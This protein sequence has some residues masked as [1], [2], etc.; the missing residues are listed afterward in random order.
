MTGLNL[1][2]GR[3]RE[4]LPLSTSGLPD[5]PVSAF[6]GLWAWPAV[7]PL[8]KALCFRNNYNHTVI[9]STEQESR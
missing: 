3:L 7:I 4:G 6:V 2:Y 5:S 1:Q 9:I 8:A